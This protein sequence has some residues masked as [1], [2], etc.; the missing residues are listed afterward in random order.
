[1]LSDAQGAETALQEGKTSVKD[2][3]ASLTIT[4]TSLVINKGELAPQY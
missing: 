1:V 3:H 4:E 2:Y